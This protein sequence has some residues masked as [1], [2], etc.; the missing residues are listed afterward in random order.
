[1]DLDGRTL[2]VT[3]DGARARCPEGVE[4]VWFHLAQ[5]RP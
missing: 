4:T 3:A 1:M 2:V 5:D